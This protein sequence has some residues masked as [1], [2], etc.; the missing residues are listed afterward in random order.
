[1]EDGPPIQDPVVV[2]AVSSI[3]QGGDIQ[4]VRDQLEIGLYAIGSIP[5]SVILRN[6]LTNTRSLAVKVSGY[7]NIS[8]NLQ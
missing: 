6:P 8:D 5:T 2:H 7:K 1:M 4:T 3:S